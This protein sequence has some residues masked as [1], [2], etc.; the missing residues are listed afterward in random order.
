MGGDGPHRAEI[1]EAGSGLGAMRKLR[2]LMPWT[3][4]W[5]DFLGLA[6]LRD[7]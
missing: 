2:S 6:Y 3:A 5:E 1:S 4:V 7:H